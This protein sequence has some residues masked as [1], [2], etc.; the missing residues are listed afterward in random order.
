MQHHRSFKRKH[1]PFESLSRK[2]RGNAVV[3]LRQRILRDKHVFGGMFTSH[4]ILNEP[5]RPPLYNQWFDFI[6]LGKDKFTLW[7]AFI[8]TAQA[9]FW[10]SIEDIARE[11]ATTLLSPEEQE[12]EFNFESE[13]DAFDAWGKPTMYRMIFRDYT[14]PQFNGKTY[15]DYC[16]ELEREIISFEPP[17]V[18]ESF[19]LDHSYGYCIG[20]HIVIEAEE[21]T[22]SVI[23]QAIARFRELGETN[24]QALSPVPRDRLP[25][26]IEYDSLAE[27]E[28]WSPGLC[29][30]EGHFRE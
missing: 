16:R 1:R 3:R 30:R 9:S 10:D 6:F 28:R 17:A 25:L 14:Y 7:N 26:K 8:C 24:W 18:Y 19:K 23:E 20:L 15:R 22:R 5:G 13:P 29:V 4:L 2:K 27:V 11:R 12:K 21:I